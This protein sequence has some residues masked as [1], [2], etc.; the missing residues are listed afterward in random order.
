MPTVNEFNSISK[1]KYCNIGNSTECFEDTVNRVG[2]AAQSVLVCARCGAQHTF[3][4]S[5]SSKNGYES[6]LL[7]P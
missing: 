6:F 2:L 5:G 1:F 7:L 4:A 3:C